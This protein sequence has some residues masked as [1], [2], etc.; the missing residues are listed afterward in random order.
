[1]YAAYNVAY[2][3]VEPLRVWE[4]DINLSHVLSALDCTGEANS[5]PLGAGF[6]Y[7]IQSILTKAG[8][9]SLW[10]SK[11]IHEQNQRS[12][13][14]SKKTT[15]FCD[16]EESG[17]WSS[18]EAHFLRARRRCLQPFVDRLR[19]DLPDRI[20]VDL[21]DPVLRSLHLDTVLFSILVDRL[22]QDQVN[23]VIGTHEIL[24]S[25]F[26]PL[27]CLKCA[28]MPTDTLPLRFRVHSV[29]PSSRSYVAGT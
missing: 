7:R 24:M 28:V 5:H 4:G 12:H 1:M 11:S 25:F 8:K 13:P 21:T 27:R 23:P 22:I 6:V 16:I 9:S 15:G 29:I 20:V 18:A 17:E 3:G 26:H 19:E 10:K 14:A 2:G